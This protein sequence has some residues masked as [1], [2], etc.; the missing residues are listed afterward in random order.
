MTIND[1]DALLKLA[2][3][4]PRTVEAPAGLGDAILRQIQVTKQER[5]LIRLGRLGWV[6]RL[7][8]AFVAA[9]LLILAALVVIAIG[10]S[11]PTLRAHLL[12]E[13]HGGPDRTGIMV[14]PGPQGVPVVAWDVTRPGP[15]PF[16][17]M[18]LVQDDR[19]YVAD[20]SGIV[21]ALDAA[22]GRRILW[23]HATG[24]PARGAPAL[25]GD[26]LIL[27]TDAGDVIA[28]A[29]ADGAPVWHQAIG[30]SPISGSMLEADG[31]IYV[32][33]EDGTFVALDGRTGARLWTADVGGPVTRGAALADGV[34]YVGATGGRFSALD[35]TT[36]KDR[37]RVELGPGD[38][39]TPLV[40]PGA[41]FVGRGLLAPDGPHDVVALDRADGA[42]RWA[43]RAPSGRQV[44][45]GALANGFL[46]GVSDDGSIYALDPASGARRWT[47]AAASAQ[48]GT[49]GSIVGNVLYVTTADRNVQAFDATTGIH[50]WTVNV[51]GVPTQA[52][53]VDGSLFVGTSLGHVYALRDPDPGATP[54]VT[55]G[56]S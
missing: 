17:T 43:F 12:S 13:Y 19:V 44:F 33:N 38:V 29:T 26:L 23:E 42:N 32:G 50:L 2:I 1:R 45:P 55:P 25:L 37:W 9:A 35:A 11:R 53:V 14:G 21:A 6:P 5:G 10:L 24:S 47:V 8:P 39:G 15:L 56:G 51:V 7:T 52:A 20:G 28:L 16:T 48:L 41:V 27:G 30:S 54:G 34:V 49:L 4:A 31:R 22:N 36:G 18:P 46:Y 3:S 40:G